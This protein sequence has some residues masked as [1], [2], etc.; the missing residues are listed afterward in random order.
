MSYNVQTL[1]QDITG[2]LHGTTTNQIV[3]LTQSTN[4]NLINR[5]ARELMLDVDPQETKRTMEFVA[6]IFNSV[7]DYPIAADVKGNKIIDI[8]P[9]VQRLPQDVWLQVY[10]QAFDVF[11]Q[12]LFSLQNM[13]TLNFNSSLKTLRIN[14]PW[15]NPP[16]IINQAEATTDNGTWTAAGT[17]SN[18]STN[19]TNFAQGAGSLQF[20]V[21]TGTAYVENSTSQ[22]INLS[23]VVNQAYQFVWVYVPDA[24]KLINVKLR[25]GSSS[26]NYYEG[27]ATQTQQGTVF[28]NGW[29]LCQF[30][31]TS[32]T[33]TGTPNSSSITYLRV[34]LTVT[35]AMTACLVNGINSI[36]GTILQYEYYSKYLFRNL[37][38]GAYQEVVLDDS[39]LINLDTES[40]N[41]LTY[42]VAV[43]AVQQQQGLDATFYDGPY[44]ENKYQQALLRYKAMYKSELQKPQSQ[45]Y[46]M[47]PTGYGRYF[48]GTWG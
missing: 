24:S 45:Y 6:P 36:L 35:G 16:V 17:A 34:T 14:A 1:Q 3:G 23:E 28:V 18:I 2:I 33:T 20:D 7:Y 46:T 47:P 32:S 42:K 10:N 30:P 21:T 39:D 26:A 29:N 31:W 22:A 48:G 9:Q 44:F 27:T 43:L 13:F 11:K 37:S 38:T 4:Y 19:N 40:Y 25:W 5:A 15:L 12:N 41:L 8:F